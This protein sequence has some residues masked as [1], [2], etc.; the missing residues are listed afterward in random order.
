MGRM[1]GSGSFGEIY[2][3]KDIQTGKEVAVK[4]EQ[5]KVRRPQVIEEAKILQEFRGN[6][7]FPKYLWYGREGDYHIMVIEMLGPSLEDLFVYCGQKLS[8]KTVL[9][10]AD[11][12]VARIQTMHEK[13][14]IHRDLKPE[15]IL[16]GLEEN[17]NT[18]YLIDYGLAKK[19][20]NGNEHIPIREGKSLTGTARYASAAT[21]L[22]IEQ[23]R[24]D[25]L[26]GAG[27]VLLYLLK[28]KLP[29]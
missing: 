17:A 11:Q 20:K 10:L 26:E 18:L 27:Y 12:L 28:G 3:G 16:M 6:V 25:D 5:L 19:W 29:W 24:R 15:N 21:H 9:L 13:G 4:F 23:S 22:G 7:G 1:I 2:L 8:L 14:Y